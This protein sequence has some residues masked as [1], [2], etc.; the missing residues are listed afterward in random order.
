MERSPLS[1]RTKSRLEDKAQSGFKLPLRKEN[2]RSTSDFPHYGNR[3][4]QSQPYLLQRKSNPLQSRDHESWRIFAK[5]IV[6]KHRST[7][8]S[9]KLS[10]SSTSQY[11]IPPNISRSTDPRLTQSPSTAREQNIA[12]YIL[13][14]KSLGHIHITCQLNLQSGPP[15]PLYCKEFFERALRYSMLLVRGTPASGKTILMNLI[16]DHIVRKFPD[17]RVHV[18][19]GWPAGMCY[20]DSQKYL[21]KQVG[22]PRDVLFAAK[23]TIVCIDDA[24]HLT[25]TTSFSHSSKI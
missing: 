13:P 21:E 12:H 11:Q 16:H 14:R 2:I 5:T 20:Q 10:W 17:F 4:M 3:A 1:D 24:H 23:K 18:F 22:M 6:M 25:M 8:T 15:G 19:R 9:I 7:K